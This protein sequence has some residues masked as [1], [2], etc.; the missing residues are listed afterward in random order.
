VL[1]NNK[2][3]PAQ[4]VLQTSG[5]EKPESKVSQII[6]VPIEDREEKHAKRLPKRKFVTTVHRRMYYETRSKT[7]NR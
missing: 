2:K 3:E 5:Q 4:E 6:S 1:S 7:R